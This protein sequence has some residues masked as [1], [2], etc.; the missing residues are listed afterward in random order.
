MHDSSALSSL[1]LFPLS[2]DLTVAYWHRVT[3]WEDPVPWYV[4]IRD[5]QFILI[6]FA[7]TATY[8]SFLIRQATSPT[9]RDSLIGLAKK[10][11]LN[12]IVPLQFD[13][14][15]VGDQR[16]H[17]FKK[18]SIDHFRELWAQEG[19][20]TAQI[21]A[22]DHRFWDFYKDKPIVCLL[23]PT[24]DPDGRGLFCYDPNMKRIV[25]FYAP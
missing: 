21:T 6:R 12:G 14:V 9:E 8:H 15:K 3:N 4:E 10:T 13:T 20:T 5:S 24:P 19:F 16:R 11:F 23:D 1:R 2:H 17:W 25:H 22:I 18:Y 7:D